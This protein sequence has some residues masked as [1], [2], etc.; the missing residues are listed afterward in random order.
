MNQNCP[1]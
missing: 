1:F